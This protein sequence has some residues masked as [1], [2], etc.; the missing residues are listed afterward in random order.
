MAWGKTLQ[1]FNSSMSES[2]PA[3]VGSASST[4]FRNEEQTQPALLRCTRG[5]IVAQ[6]L[7]ILLV[8]LDLRAA[9]PVFSLDPPPKVGEE[10]LEL[11]NVRRAPRRHLAKPEDAPFVQE[12]L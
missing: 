2:T 7:L 3:A 11:F 5:L 1:R 8:V 9:H 4:C 10:E 12:P 6:P